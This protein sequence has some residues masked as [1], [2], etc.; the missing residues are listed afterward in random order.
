M[1]HHFEIYK[2]IINIGIRNNVPLDTSLATL[3][4]DR[5]L[6]HCLCTSPIDDGLL[7]KLS[8]HFG[9]HI[10]SLD[11][12]INCTEQAHP[13]SLLGFVQCFLV[14]NLKW[15]QEEKYSK[16]SASINVSTNSI[17]EAARALLSS[18]R[19]LLLMIA[20]L[21]FLS[22]LIANVSFFFLSL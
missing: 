22:N 1:D 12:W 8:S 17:K 21:L 4:C 13:S 9:S 18:V 20:I 16:V 10:L 7:L 19:V 3:W 5:R 15:V 14:H 2:L 11:F 6:N